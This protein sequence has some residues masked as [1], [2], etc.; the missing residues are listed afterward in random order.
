M[1]DNAK[2]IKRFR[3]VREPVIPDGAPVKAAEKRVA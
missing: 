2:D 1:P 3:A